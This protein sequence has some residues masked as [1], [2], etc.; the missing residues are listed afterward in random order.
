MVNRNVPF[1][2]NTVPSSA[3]SL[4][5]FGI[6]L[7]SSNVS[8][9]D[10]EDPIPKLGVWACDADRVLGVTPGWLDW[11]AGVELAEFAAAFRFFDAACEPPVPF[12]A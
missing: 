9:L 8:M 3:T 12:A 2:A 7:Q 11:G 4:P 6:A 5:S 10:S 1:G